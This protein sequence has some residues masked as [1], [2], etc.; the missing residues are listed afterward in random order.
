M[1]NPNKRSRDDS[2][3]NSYHIRRRQSVS[4]QDRFGDRTNRERLSRSND[5]EIKLFTFLGLAAKANLCLPGGAAVVV[6]NIQCVGLDLPALFAV[7]SHQ[8]MQACLDRNRPSSQPPRDH[9]AMID[10]RRCTR[11]F[12]AVAQLCDG[13]NR[14]V[15]NFKDADAERTGK[16]EP[17]LWTSSLRPSLLKASWTCGCDARTLRRRSE[18]ACATG[19]SWNYEKQSDW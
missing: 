5:S 16:S 15:T 4:A 10:G 8:R 11:F 1:R 3:A 17:S 12:Q 18:L 19:Y 7:M 9:F 6:G 13:S 14:N 2:A